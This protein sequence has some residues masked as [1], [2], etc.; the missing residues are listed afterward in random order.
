[1]RSILIL[2][3]G[4]RTY[5]SVLLKRRNR[6]GLLD[7]GADGDFVIHRAHMRPLEPH[8]LSVSVFF[9]QPQP[10]PSRSPS[11]LRWRPRKLGRTPVL[12][13]GAAV[14]LTLHLHRHSVPP[15]N[16]SVG[17]FLISDCDGLSIVPHR[18]PRNPEAPAY[19]PVSRPGLLLS[20]DGAAQS[21]YPPPGPV[22]PLHDGRAPT[23]ADALRT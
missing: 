15:L 7:H 6:R 13:Q 4:K 1:M 18:F 3:L 5:L 8:T 16:Y 2:D 19:P 14:G 21:G 22:K 11:S 20:L 12:A 9:G 17:H 23:E 10:F